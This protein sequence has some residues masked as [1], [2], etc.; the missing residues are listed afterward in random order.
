MPVSHSIPFSQQSSEDFPS[1]SC[2][3]LPQAQG[4]VLLV[5]WPGLLG[6]LA[7]VAGSAHGVVLV[8]SSNH[9]NLAGRFGEWL[10]SPAPRRESL[11]TSRTG[12]VKQFLFRGDSPPALLPAS[13]C[14]RPPGSTPCTQRSASLR[15]LPVAPGSGC[16]QR[17]VPDSREDAAGWVPRGS[18]SSCCTKLT[19]LP[20][21]GKSHPKQQQ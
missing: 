15:S 14:R 8:S 10:Q 1:G 18:Q 4:R 21:S 16:S 11:P 6:S 2:L 7:E 13:W 20:F 12:K 3:Q 17:P 5:L 9:F 19:V